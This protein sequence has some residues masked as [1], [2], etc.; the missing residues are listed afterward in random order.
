MKVKDWIIISLITIIFFS[1]IFTIKRG[2]RVIHDFKTDTTYIYTQ[3]RDTIYLAKTEYVDRVDTVYVY[4]TLS[5]QSIHIPLQFERK[6]YQTDN[7]SLDIVGYKPSLERIEL[8]PKTQVITN[9][10][11][12][13]KTIPPKW[14]SGAILGSNFGINDPYYYIGGRI[15]YNKGI[16]NA[17]VVLGYSPNI[18]NVIGEARIGIDFFR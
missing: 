8:Y 14:Q 7:Y 15:R 12:L 13:T 17:E 3:F 11:T 4:D 5:G 10:H 16:F 18:N 2:E 6:T 9:T 1:I